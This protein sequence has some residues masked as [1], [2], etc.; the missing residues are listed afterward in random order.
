MDLDAKQ[1]VNYNQT[2]ER[3]TGIAVEPTAL[4]ST[5]IAFAHGLDLFLVPLAPSKQFDMLDV[6]L[7]IVTLGGS[8]VLLVVS[9][10]VLNFFSERKKLDLL[11][12]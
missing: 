5:S 4:E 9:T 6:N 11:W 1:I 3:L 8:L 10:F 2:V 7:D 12:A